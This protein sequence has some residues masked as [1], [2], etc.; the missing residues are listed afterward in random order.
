VAAGGAARW[1]RMS[2][3][4]TASRVESEREMAILTSQTV[5][6]Y[7]PAIRG[8]ALRPGERMRSAQRTLH[9]ARFFGRH[10]APRLR[11]SRPAIPSPLFS[12]R[13]HRTKYGFSFAPVRGD[14]DHWDINVF[15]GPSQVDIDPYTI[16]ESY[17]RLKTTPEQDC[18][19]LKEAKRI[20]AQKYWYS[21]VYR[22]CAHAARR[23]MIVGGVKLDDVLFD[24]P[25]RLQADVNRLAK[26]AQ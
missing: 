19:A 26:P 21:V 22:N 10:R 20:K 7:H 2:R 24:W 14:W 3:R 15:L 9:R 13:Y 16:S 4:K 1:R 5:G 25:S 8:P 18:A 11:A 23:V 6:V 12:G 17:T